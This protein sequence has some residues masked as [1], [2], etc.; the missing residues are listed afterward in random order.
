MTAA[1]EHGHEIADAE[2]EH[3]REM[4]GFVFGQR[5][6]LITRIQIRRKES[7]HVRIIRTAASSPRR[8]EI[9][10]GSRRTSLY[11]I[12]FVRLRVLRDFVAIS[13]QLLY[14]ARMFLRGQIVGKYKILSTIGSGGFGTVFLADD[15]WIDKRV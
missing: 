5:D 3:A 13:Q 7:M 6:G 2:A 10:E 15:T 9:H 8:H 1:V 11:G 4:L 12:Y 14:S